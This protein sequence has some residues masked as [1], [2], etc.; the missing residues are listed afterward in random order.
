MTSRR[1]ESAFPTDEAH[2]WLNNTVFSSKT[3]HRKKMYVHTHTYICNNNNQRQRGCPRSGWAMGGVE[4][5]VP[6]RGWREDGAQGA[7]M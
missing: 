1:G 4:G 6:K 3:I 7:D 2:Y 5:E